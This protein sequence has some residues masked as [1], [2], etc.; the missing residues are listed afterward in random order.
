MGADTRDGM[1]DNGNLETSKPHITII[2][3]INIYIYI[4]YLMICIFQL[5]MFQVR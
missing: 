5:N 4:I 3:Y 2:L 1:G